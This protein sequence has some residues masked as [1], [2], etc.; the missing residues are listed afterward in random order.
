MFNKTLVE[1]TEKFIEQLKT[2]PTTLDKTIEAT[3][4][5]P[6]VPPQ[7]TPLEEFTTQYQQSGYTILPAGVLRK[8]RVNR[9]FIS[10]S[11]LEPFIVVDRSPYGG[12]VEKNC[13]EVAFGPDGVTRMAAQA[14][15]YCCGQHVAA[16]AWVETTGTIA[17]KNYHG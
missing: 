5:K 6:P 10:G 4:K 1:V 8:V 9:A 7:K 2:E 14:E 16:G 17:V 15:G 12:I 3:E 11:R 13:D